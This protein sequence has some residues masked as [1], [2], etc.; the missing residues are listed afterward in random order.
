MDIEKVLNVL[1]YWRNSL[2]DA[3]YMSI[4]ASKF[5]NAVVVQREEVRKGKI[6]EEKTKQIFEKANEL[7][8]DQENSPDNCRKN[9]ETNG[10]VKKNDEQIYQ[11]EEVEIIICPIVA[12][13]EKKHGI[14]NKNLEK[15]ISPIY[16]PA[17]INSR[18]ELKLKTDTIPWIPRDYL[19]P[20]QSL[21][22]TPLGS[23]D[24][25]DK[26]LSSRSL[27]APEEG[28]TAYWRYCDDMLRHVT[29]KS[30]DEFYL[31]GYEI[32][33]DAF[34]LIEERVQKI[35]Q[36]LITLY[37][38]ILKKKHINKLLLRYTN[39][40]DEKLENLLTEEE[41]T[42]ICLKHLGQMSGKHFLS[43]SQRQSVHH[44]FTLKDGEI[45]AVNGPPGTGK[46]TL[47][48]SIIASLWVEAAL[49]EG[50]PPI[51]VAVSANNQAVTNII[52][53]FAKTDEIER[54][55]NVLEYWWLSEIKS[56]GLYMPANNKL[57]EA[58]KKYQIIDNQGGGF[59]G[60][61]N[62]DDYVKVNRN[63]FIEKC[64]KFA[65][66]NFHNLR[67]CRKFLHEQLNKTVWEIKQGIDIYINL[68]KQDEVIKENYEKYGGIDE[69]IKK[70]KLE[71]V[72]VEEETKILNGVIEGWVR[73]IQ[74]APWWMNVFW[75]LPWVRKHILWR[76]E[77]YVSRINYK[78]GTD[79]SS[80]SGIME[81]L[82]RKKEE[83]VSEKK[84]KEE[85]LNKAMKEKDKLINLRAKLKEWAEKNEINFDREPQNLYEFLGP[86][87]PVL[88]YRAF[89]LAT[90]YWECRWLEEMQGA[91]LDKTR[92]TSFTEDALRK[93]WKRLAKLTPCFVSTLYT[94]PKFF[95]VS[96]SSSSGNNYLYD[97]I[98][99]LIIDEAGQ[100]SPEVAG[101]VFAL[102]KK[103]LVVGDVLQIEPVWNIL[104]EI[105][106]AN[107]EKNDVVKRND[108][109]EIESF[110]KSGMAASCGCVMK[111][112]QRA[113]KYKVFEE[114]GM[115]LTEHRRCYESI[116]EYCNELAYKGRL[117]PERKD[118]QEFI[119]PL[120]G[121]RLIKG[122]AKKYMG[123]WGNE[124]EAEEIVKWILKNKE[125]LEA[126]YS[127]EEKAGKDIIEIIGIVTPFTYQSRIIKEK[128]EKYNLEGITVGTV[129]SLQGAE[130]N[131]VI[132]SPVYD[133]EFKG[134]FF[135]DKNIN[136]LNVAVSRA[137][138][139]F[140]VFGNIEIF[141]E[142]AEKPSGLLAKYIK[143]GGE[144]P[145]ELK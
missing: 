28:W 4:D 74:S 31:E 139:S 103:A 98:D 142:M 55:K 110:M 105:D 1:N 102:A 46:T 37:D 56:Y 76:N 35:S 29:G 26:F 109:K 34:I 2:A 38:D 100:I 119:L 90:H 84:L 63:T 128:L 18:G 94:L 101:A 57:K 107:L 43:Y 7:K 86:I 11:K 54:E 106:K 127:K 51:I 27:P 131:I 83:L 120:M 5:R 32:S 24:E 82:R 133:K 113:S 89:K 111:I 118:P 47:L 85:I 104:K 61:I 117:L 114:R 40:E 72:K 3:E 141:D 22:I 19:E 123:S 16:I 23:I 64:S 121:Y 13:L 70:S 42:L 68:K 126:Y 21:K 6:N 138:D 20:V 87:D 116:I 69:F 59:E 15:I 145:V 136:M 96:E 140:L 81:F 79:L 122:R 132:F 25:F 88:K 39:I 66:K 48:H 10:I 49:N 129:H 8:K 97:F 91:R 92:Y 65:G 95:K 99:L 52:D 9:S 62:S 71:I 108:E 93:R 30:I 50:E 44:F 67:E 45:L 80:N 75:F 60:I 130:R 78:I 125:I 134:D 17:N 12:F 143:K 41:E 14:E 33:S 77:E 135:F 36:S 53:S 124:L 137:K 115:F 144:V 58:E 73:H 112:A